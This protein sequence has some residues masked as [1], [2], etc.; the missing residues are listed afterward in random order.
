MPGLQA[1]LYDIGRMYDIAQDE[2]KEIKSTLGGLKEEVDNLM[3]KML[4]QDSIEVDKK[5][6]RGYLCILLLL[7]LL[8]SYV[9]ISV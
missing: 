5:Q 6:V 9:D 4:Q 2:D 7:L 3:V 8:L 1:Q